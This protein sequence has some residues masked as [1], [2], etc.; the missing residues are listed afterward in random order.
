MNIEEIRSQI[1]KNN[2]KLF[3]KEAKMRRRKRFLG[4]L[5]TASII[6]IMAVIMFVLIMAISPKEERSINSIIGYAEGNMDALGGDSEEIVVNETAS[7]TDLSLL[8]PVSSGKIS[9][10]FGERLDPFTNE[11]DFHKG[12]D[13]AA[14]LGTPI[15]AAESGTVVTADFNQYAGNYIIIEHSSNVKTRYLHCEKLLVNEG[16][17]VNKGDKIALVGSTGNSTGPHLHFEVHIDDTA[18][19]PST[20]IDD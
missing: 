2:P 15:F 19:N 20:V 7:D 5:T 12:L 13:I 9:S 11:P 10:G 8:M 4:V 3:P 17:T 16:D 6:T 18:V 14:D 1:I